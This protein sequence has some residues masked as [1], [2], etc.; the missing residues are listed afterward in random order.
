MK[1]LAALIPGVISF[2]ILFCLPAGGA[3]FDIKP[4]RLELSNENQLDKL[5]INNF[6]DS[7]F[8]IQIRAYEWRQNDKGEDVYSETQDIIIF[9][10]ITT[11]KSGEEAYIRIGTKVSAG[12]TEKPYRI[13]I[14]EMPSGGAGKQGANIRLYTKVGIPVFIRPLA[15]ESRVEIE[16]ASVNAG[17][18]DVKVINGGN[19][20]FIVTG[21]HVQGFDAAGKASFERDIG[22]W[23][24]LSGTEKVYSTQIP[25]EV[26]GGIRTLNIEVQTKETTLT[27]QLPLNGNLCGNRTETAENR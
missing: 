8:S 11:I 25:P 4:V 7:D 18:L 3:S 24:L 16:N 17:I 1:Y 12:K 14:E 9:P 2:S 13:Y 15:V 23:Y 19:T 10:K 6:S 22:G 21:I 20:H 5:A 26:C 27:Q